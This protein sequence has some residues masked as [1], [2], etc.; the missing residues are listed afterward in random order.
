MTASSTTVSPWHDAIE[1]HIW[2]NDRI[3]DACAALTDEQ[4]RQNVPGTFGPIMATLHHL[5]GTDGWYLS[6]FLEFDNPITDDTDVTIDLLREA[7]AANGERYRT[8]LAAETDPERDVVEEGD[9]W[10]F[11]TPVA[12]RYAQT[13]QHG[14]DHRSQVC[15][16][17]T[18]LGIEPPQIDVWAY[19]E[20]TGRSR[21]EYLTP[22]TG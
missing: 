18:A 14:T 1:H 8:V 6:F 20:A 21:A 13:V 7:N 4:L 11:H 10:R 22:P 17:L 12:F 9:G 5:I 2:A 15:T 3:L 16:G 19:G